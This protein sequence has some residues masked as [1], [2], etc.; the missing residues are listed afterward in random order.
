MST[1]TGPKQELNE[2][3][4]KALADE[5]GIIS[6]EKLKEQFG[7]DL[8]GICLGSALITSLSIIFFE[9][10]ALAKA[11]YSVKYYKDPTGYNGRYLECET[12]GFKYCPVDMEHKF[13]KA[14]SSGG[15]IVFPIFRTYK[16]GKPGD[17]CGGCL[18]AGATHQ[19]YPLQAS[20]RS[21]MPTQLSLV[22]LRD[23]KSIPKAPSC[24]AKR[25]ES[26]LG[27]RNGLTTSTTGTKKCATINKAG[28]GNTAF[29]RKEGI[30]PE[31]LKDMDTIQDDRGFV[32]KWSKR[33]EIV[34][35]THYE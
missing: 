27:R 15:A 35:H 33:S 32:S 28:V 18:G 29:Y 3:N 23:A 9:R 12:N 26:A 16:I 8:D 19:C 6:L 4:Y 22:V 25:K 20:S 24:P 11:D 14:S 7:L 2:E 10:Q 31:L 34:M 1:K 13:G 17:E 30:P 5:N 21:R